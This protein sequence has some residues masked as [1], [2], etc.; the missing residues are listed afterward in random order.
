MQESVNRESSYVVLRRP[1]SA[2]PAPPAPSIA[3]DSN[4]EVS[5]E[6]VSLTRAERADLQ[7][8]PRTLAIAMPMPMKLIEPTSNS[9]PAG[10]STNSTWGVDA[11]G[12]T[13]SAFKGDGIVVAVLDTGIDRTHRAFR[14]VQLVERNFTSDVDND[15]HGHGTHCA[16]TL[17]GQDIDN[18]RIGVAPNVDRALIGKVIANNAGSS[19]DIAEAI[20]WA[21]NNGAHVVSLS[22]GIDFPGYVQRLTTT[23][24]PVGPATSQALQEYRANVDLFRTLVDLVRA[25]GEFQQG[26]VLVAASGNESNRPNYEIAV[27]PPAAASGVIAVGA[28]QRGPN[29]FSVSSFSNIDVDVAAPGVDVISA[30]LGGELTSWDGTSMATPHVAGVA[31]LWA[32]K[33]LQETNRVDSRVLESE[34]LASGSTSMLVPGAQFEDVGTGLVQAP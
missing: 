31:A 1:D 6:E 25:Q 19:R 22:V 20:L 11:V 8:D 21:V 5:L 12:A 26:A 3:R 29:G 30:K 27:A 7:R 33:L 16:G 34:L 2:L 13:N 17:F 24:I 23:G 18:L 32:Q 28:I 15:V 10:P 14:N 9:E 4:I